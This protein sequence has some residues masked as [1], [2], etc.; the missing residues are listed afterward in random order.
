M[1]A[2][3]Q[4]LISLG[5]NQ[6]TRFEN[7]EKAIRLIQKRVGFIIE[8]SKLYESPSW[9]FE[10]DAFYNAAIWIET[11]YNADE[12]LNKILKIETDLGRFRSGNSGYQARIIDLDIIAF[13]NDIIQTS[14]LQI[15]HPLMQNRKFVLI[16]IRD[17]N[18]NWE[19]PVLKKNI[20]YLIDNCPDNSDLIVVEKRL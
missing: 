3:H 8:K 15:P 14:D 11:E 17:L 5:S 12:I 10:S 9:G 20:S 6:G 16:P 1:K 13:D 2:L 19:H 7:I 18:P 4:V